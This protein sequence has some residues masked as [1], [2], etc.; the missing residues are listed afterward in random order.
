MTGI[1]NP[2]DGNNT[3][4][5]Q[6]SPRFGMGYWR[7]SKYG[8]YIFGGM[9]TGNLADVWKFNI[10]S[11]TWSWVAG[12]NDTNPT[13]LPPNTPA[14]RFATQCTVDSNDDA[15]CFGGAF[16]ETIAS[17]E[18]LYGSLW[19][20]QSNT[21]TW[22]LLSGSDTGNEIVPSV[23]RPRYAHGIAVDIIRN[24]LYVIGGVGYAPNVT[25]AAGVRTQALMD[26]WRYTNTTQSSND[27][28]TLVIS[29]SSSTTVTRN[30]TSLTLA[31]RLGLAVSMDSVTGQRPRLWVFGGASNVSS[32][33]ATLYN[34]IW[35]YQP[36]A[37]CNT[38]FYINPSNSSACLPCGSNATSNGLV[39]LCPTGYFG[40]PNIACTQCPAY[41]TRTGAT[42]QTTNASACVTT[43]TANSPPSGCPTCGT[44]A[45]LNGTT[46][47]CPANFYGDPAIA[48]TLCPEYFSRSDAISSSTTIADCI[49]TSQK[50][51][52]GFYGD[53]AI[54]CERCQLD[55]YKPNTTYTATDESACIPCPENSGT[56]HRAAWNITQCL[57]KAG[58]GGIGSL[59]TCVACDL[60][61]EKL[62]ISDEECTRK[63]YNPMGSL[64]I[65]DIVFYII[66][67]VGSLFIVSIGAVVFVIQKRRRL[68]RRQ[69][70]SLQNQQLKGLLPGPMMSPSHLGTMQPIMAGTVPRPAFGTL[71]QNNLGPFMSANVGATATFLRPSSLMV[72]QGAS[73]VGSMQRNSTGNNWGMGTMGGNTF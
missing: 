39:C 51:S 17:V 13:S 32:G 66:V 9:N 52:P 1:S 68:R 5:N 36:F 53:P 18:V 61:S 49:E 54:K 19:K 65:S 8:L 55:T 30:A 59:N 23:P 56:K 73:V 26:I 70:Q 20:F 60:S 22:V 71:P 46:C 3:L 48:C 38:G 69:V 57:C 63:H 21:L 37:G 4:L 16:K 24:E 15:Y 34:D 41:S 10:A 50:C 12:V 14:P 6:P 27:T 25:D 35:L 29:N 72:G 44:N 31:S 42:A 40:N 7:D 67:G 58:Y 2:T 33:S 62:I 11:F 28:W 45:V 43:C 47:F 64:G